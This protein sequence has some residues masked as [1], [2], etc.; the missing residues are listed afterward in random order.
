MSDV[1]RCQ[2][3]SD[4]RCQMSDVRCQMS[5]VRCQ[6]YGWTGFVRD[7]LPIGKPIADPKYDSHRHRGTSRPRRRCEEGGRE[8]RK[9]RRSSR[10]HL[11]F[12]VRAV[13]TVGEE[14]DV[15]VGPR[16]MRNLDYVE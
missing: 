6:M 2:M 9:H 10:G 3:S 15:E 1:I 16:D 13:S 14:I 11:S 7:I 5:D 8:G 12:S 4:V